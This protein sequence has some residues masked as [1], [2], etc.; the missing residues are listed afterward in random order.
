[1]L[2][3]QFLKPSQSFSIL[4]KL[5]GPYLPLVALALLKRFIL[6]YIYML[7]QI[8]AVKKNQ[9]ILPKGW[10]AHENLNLNIIYIPWGR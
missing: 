6:H 5:T 7:S 8:V 3:Y 1:M 10:D 2:N 4:D 9:L